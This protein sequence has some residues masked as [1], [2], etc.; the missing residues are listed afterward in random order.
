MGVTWHHGQV[1]SIGVLSCQ[2]PLCVP[3]PDDVAVLPVETNRPA[4]RPALPHTPCPARTP[5]HAVPGPH[6][7]TPPGP[8]SLTPPGPQSLTPP[9]PQPTAYMTPTPLRVTSALLVI[10]CVSRRG[11]M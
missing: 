4:A 6:F 5:S 9:G 1:E 2:P 10:C 7:L 11:F 8:H 3:G